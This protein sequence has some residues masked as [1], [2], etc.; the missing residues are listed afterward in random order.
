MR[1]FGWGIDWTPGDSRKTTASIRVS[2]E[3]TSEANQRRSM[4]QK[5][6]ADILVLQITECR[7]T[8]CAQAQYGNGDYA[9]NKQFVSCRVTRLFNTTV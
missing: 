2:E 5:A 7:S 8:V 1:S 4:L 6:R 3:T 9:C